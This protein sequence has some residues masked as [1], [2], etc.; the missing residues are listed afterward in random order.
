MPERDPS[1]VKNLDRYGHDALPWSRARDRLAATPDPE[2]P[3]A[4][5]STFLSTTRP[6]GRVHTAPVGTMWHEGDL[7]FTSG[8]GTR[9]SR[10]LAENPTGTLAIRLDGIDVVLEGAASRVTDSATLEALARDYRAGGWPVT[11]DGAAF[12]ADFSAPSAGPPP[13]QLY[14]F[15]FETVFGVATVEPWGATRWRFAR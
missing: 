3:G 10:N 8:D 5:T 9:K 4:D 15:R 2:H 6:D 14:R 12:T 7:Y 1:E 13:W 11:V